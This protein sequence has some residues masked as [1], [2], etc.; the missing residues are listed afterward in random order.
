MIF[1]IKKVWDSWWQR[2]VSRMCC[3]R[4]DLRGVVQVEYV[5]LVGTVAMSI[6][7]A[8]VGDKRIGPTS[9]KQKLH[10]DYQEMLDAVAVPCP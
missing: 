6:M 2:V 3:F 8:L 1:L 10:K 5:I 4:R 9:M 7:F